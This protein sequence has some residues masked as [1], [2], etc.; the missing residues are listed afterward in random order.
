MSPAQDGSGFPFLAPC[1]VYKYLCGMSVSSIQIDLLEVQ[2][3]EI[4][5]ILERVSSSNI[6]IEISNCV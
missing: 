5:N 6:N 2:D 4:K 3:F 1:V